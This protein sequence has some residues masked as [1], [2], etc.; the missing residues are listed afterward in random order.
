MKE[1]GMNNQAVE[2]REIQWGLSYNP[3]LGLGILRREIKKFIKSIIHNKLQL[4][5]LLFCLQS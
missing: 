1:D 5:K 2:R 3:K 4:S